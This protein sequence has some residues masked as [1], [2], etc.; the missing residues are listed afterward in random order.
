[1]KKA[2][3][4]IQCVAPNGETGTFLYSEKN[5]NGY[6]LVSPMM[7]DSVA[8][9]TWAKANGWQRCEGPSPVGNYEHRGTVHDEIK[10]HMARAFFASAYA[11]QAEECGQPLSGEI[12]DQLP[13]ETDP[14][15]VH[16]ADTLAADMMRAN[17]LTSPCFDLESLFLRACE[18]AENSRD[19][20][21]RE[22]TP[23]MFGHYCAMQ[24]MGHGVGLADA[25]GG[26]VYDDIR[27]PYV[28]FG[29]HSLAQDYFTADDE[30]DAA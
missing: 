30:G 14:A 2:Y 8:L 11:D 3:L 27:V 23:E 16:A 1:M 20:G 9:F 24:A 12:M 22:H 13:D 28:E 17:G 15:A 26:A 21:D 5:E 4:A 7:P 25:F 10:R 18:I 29:S 19:R 6:V